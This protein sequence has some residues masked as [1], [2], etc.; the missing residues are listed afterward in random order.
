MGQA[1]D[2]LETKISELTRKLDDSQTRQ[3]G[4]SQKNITQNTQGGGKNFKP[5]NWNN[6]GQRSFRP[7]TISG[8][9]KIINKKQIDKNFQEIE[10]CNGNLHSKHLPSHSTRT[11][12]QHQINIINKQVRANFLSKTPR[13]PKLSRQQIRVSTTHMCNR[14]QKYASNW[15]IPTT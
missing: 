1:Q 5:R 9:T 12:F 15:D 14:H 11:N 13:F 8:A 4:S 6:S 10:T 7:I 2:S 3:E